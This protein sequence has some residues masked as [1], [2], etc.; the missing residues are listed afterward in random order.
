MAALSN[1]PKLL[2]P[3][4][5]IH[6]PLKLIERR[7]NS[8]IGLASAMTERQTFNLTGLAK[9][10]GANGGAAFINRHLREV[11]ASERKVLIVEGHDLCAPRLRERNSGAQEQR[12]H[13]ALV[14]PPMASPS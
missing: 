12:Q 8:P 1:R 6:Q 3:L 9:M 10:V 5:F 7:A 2:L 11:G 13:L 4:S 14:R